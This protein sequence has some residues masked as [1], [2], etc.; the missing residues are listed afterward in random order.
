MACLIAA[1]TSTVPKGNAA[2]LVVVSVEA[3]LREARR[4]MAVLLAEAV[5]VRSRLRLRA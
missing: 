3:R 4:R 5:L 1:P 2:Q